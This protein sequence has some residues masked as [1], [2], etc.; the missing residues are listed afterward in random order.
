MR[1]R[2][3]IT[4]V[5]APFLVSCGQSTP[6]SALPKVVPIASPTPL[7]FGTVAVGTARELPGI[8]YKK[9]LISGV[10]PFMGG[11]SA[12]PVPELIS[13]PDGKL[14]VVVAFVDQP[15]PP[16]G[17]M[18][19]SI[20]SG[21]QVLKPVLRCNQFTPQIPGA[22]FNWER[23]FDRMQYQSQVLRFGHPP[24][25]VAFEVDSA[26]RGGTLTINKLN[27]PIEW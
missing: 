7:P 8:R 26:T 17:D 4:C 10:S 19:L 11:A 23:A 6:A 15:G 5:L 27:F 13:V 24:F 20:Q 1:I 9:K 16:A 25:A 2:L 21:T 14:W 22:Q 18:D 12:D 3:A